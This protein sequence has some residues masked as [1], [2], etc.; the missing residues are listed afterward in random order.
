MKEL[1]VISSQILPN[2][3]MFSKPKFDPK[4]ELCITTYMIQLDIKDK[5]STK[6]F[7]ISKTSKINYVR[8]SF[9][10]TTHFCNIATIMAFNE[11]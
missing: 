1:T 9:S 10:I 8:Q 3:E 2:F 11:I 4:L 5:R 7:S 6:P